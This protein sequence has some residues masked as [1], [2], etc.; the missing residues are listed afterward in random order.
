MLKSLTPQEEDSIEAALNDWPHLD[1]FIEVTTTFK[2]DEWQK[3]LCARLQKLRWQTGQR[4]LVHA[5]PQRGKSIIVS[6]RFPAWLLGAKPENRVRLAC[7]NVT[8]AARFGAVLR[9]LMTEKQ[10]RSIYPDPACHIRARQSEAEWSTPAR[11]VLSDAQPSFMALG[12][13]TGFVGQGVD[14]LIID[15]PY[16]SPQDAA[17][18]A[19]RAS[20]WMFWDE[21]ARVRVNDET[22]VVVMFHRYHEEDIAGKL[23]EQG[24]WELLRYAEIADGDYKAANGD[25]FPDPMN[26]SDGEKL[27]P[28]VSDEF[29]EK[30]QESVYAWLGQF[31]GRPS[32]KSGTMFKIGKFGEPVWA[33]PKDSVRIRYW[34]KAGADE[35][36]GDWTVGVLMAKDKD[37]FFYVEDVERFQKTAHPRNERIKQ[38]AALDKQKYGNIR[39]WIEQPPGLAKE[40]TDTV[41]RELAGY[42]VKADPVKGDKT[43]RAE[44][45]ARQVEAENVKLVKGDWIKKYLDELASFP[46]SKNDDQ[47]DASSGAFNK[48][49]GANG[50]SLDESA[51]ELL[52]SL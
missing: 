32:G 18:A 51:E 10:Y 22:N 36:K 39:I 46:N 28:R 11:E 38:V 1:N 3:H 50:I 34:D 4:I 12:L 14:T 9:N 8:H 37:G 23:L 49:A 40:S 47:V 52:A 44:P 27:S 5:P 21:S 30:Q 24:G 35:G 6:Q 25:V 26:R 16:A 43:E 45:Y 48:L 13:A 31:Q 2:L 29:I 7:Y 17:S 41:V 42:N 19:I 20:V 33:A 15:D